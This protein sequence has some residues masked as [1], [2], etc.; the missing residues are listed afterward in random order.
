MDLRTLAL[1]HGQNIPNA[2]AAN[3]GP[4]VTPLKLIAIWL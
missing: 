2:N 3:I 1:A 4:A